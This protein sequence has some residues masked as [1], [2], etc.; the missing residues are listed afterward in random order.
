MANM[1]RPQG[2]P[3]SRSAPTGPP[4][5]PLQIYDVARRKLIR[6]L[7]SATYG[8][9]AFSRDDTKLLVML[10]GTT[11]SAGTPAVEDAVSGRRVSLQGAEAIP[12]GVSPQ[13][14]AISAND[15]VVVGGSFCGYADVWNAQ[16]GRLIRR[17]NQGAEMSSADLSPDGSRLLISSWDSRATV[18]DVGSGRALVN[19]VGHTRGINYAAFTPD[20]SMVVTASLD[21]TIR[22]WNAHTGQQ[23]RVL[24]FTDIEV[25][26]AFSADGQ[27]MASAG[28]TPGLASVARVY[29]TCPACRDANALLRIAAPQAASPSRLTVLERTVVNGA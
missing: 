13:N 27:L 21:H 3:P 19:L 16:T 18:Y 8:F 22:V 26:I 6:T 4:R 5:V 14:F 12:C 7:P 20:A 17:F 29:A 28:G 25:G 24:S 23:L 2:P 9:V 11:T 10:A 15:R 1:A